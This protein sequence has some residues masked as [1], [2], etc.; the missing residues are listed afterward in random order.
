VTGQLSLQVHPSAIRR[1][2][3]KD[4]GVIDDLE[5]VRDV[6]YRLRRPAISPEYVYAHDWEEGDFVLFNN[7]GVFHSVVGA[8]AN[9]EVRLFRQCNL[10]ASRPPLGP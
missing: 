8:F 9:N 10:S 2:H 5:R 1:I 3:L 6:V 7:H 4:G